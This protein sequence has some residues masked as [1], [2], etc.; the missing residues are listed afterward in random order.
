MR[1]SIFAIA[2]VATTGCLMQSPCLA[3]TTPEVFNSF[4]PDEVAAI[5]RD[6]GYR[7]EVITA[8]NST[9]VLTGM[10]GWNVNVYF[11]DCNDSGDCRSLQYRVWLDKM[12]NYSLN[13]AN[14][15][16]HEKRFAKAY[17]N[18]NGD[19]YLEADV[20]FDRVTK[21]T[22][23]ASARFFDQLVGLFRNSLKSVSAAR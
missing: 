20:L 12:D 16:N 18:D 11:Y 4:K 2:L 6:A 10:G 5:L 8:N 7:A 21:E 15:W 19:I 14:K 9:R 3:D 23:S 13:A 17:L 22:V 1:T